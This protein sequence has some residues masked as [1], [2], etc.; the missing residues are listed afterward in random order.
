M[1]TNNNGERA[2]ISLRKVIGI[3]LLFLFLSGICV[4]ANSTQVNNV[5]ITLSNGY[6]MD[7][8]TSK[9]KVSEILEEEHIILLPDEKVTPDK[10]ETIGVN[11]TIKISK[12]SDQE[13]AIEIAQ[14]NTEIKIEDLMAVYSPIIEKIVV[15]Q[16]TIPFET[17]TKDVSN[18]TSEKQNR[19]LKEGKEGVKEVTYKVK[20]QNDKIIEKTEISSRV[21]QEPIDK[22]IQVK[23]A[24]TNRSGSSRTAKAETT[25]AS[26]ISVG[27][28]KV[29]GYCSCA[30]C[31]GK[32]TGR[33]AS[34]TIATANRT[35][36][37]PGR[38]AY[39]TKLK[40]NGIVYTV[41]D[42]GGAIKG[43][44]IDIYF[45]S[46]AQALAWGSRN[47]QVEVMN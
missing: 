19:V 45:S 23:S 7:V 16:E 25:S 31:C 3:C 40:I 46:H 21:L 39:G 43:N 17:I 26:G 36:A 27:T 10:N 41:E 32:T 2:S 11:K 29:T 14:S 30:K 33:T 35:I 4:L 38:F 44:R 15:E 8:M 13:E 18:G 1:I 24:V 47:C 12:I 9:T 34:G 20:Y 42:R 22:V 5:K 37:A 28:F 6:E